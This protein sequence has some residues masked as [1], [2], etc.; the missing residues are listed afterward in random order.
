MPTHYNLPT[1][2]IKSVPY[3]LHK[4]E[5]YSTYHDSVY[6][7]YYTYKYTFYKKR[8]NKEETSTYISC[9]LLFHVYM[10]ANNDFHFNV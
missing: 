10:R 6:N 2:N 9:G 8:I 4:A 7:V 5:N 3:L 1:F